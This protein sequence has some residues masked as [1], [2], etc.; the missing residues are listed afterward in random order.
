MLRLVAI[1][2]LLACT[3]CRSVQAFSGPR[4]AP[5]CELET[6]LRP[7]PA[8]A[9]GAIL[10]SEVEVYGRVHFTIR[11]LLVRPE[12]FDWQDLSR[13]ARSLA[14]SSESLLLAPRKLRGLESAFLEGPELPSLPLVSSQALY[15]TQSLLLLE[16]AASGISL[17]RR[18]NARDRPILEILAERRS[19]QQSLLSIE[20]KEAEAFEIAVLNWPDNAAGLAILV[21]MKLLA[22]EPGQAN[23]GPLCI[24]LTRAPLPLTLSSLEQASLADLKKRRPS[25]PPVLRE[26][27]GR[28]WMTER[29]VELA[30][31]A[32]AHSPD[33]RRGALLSLAQGL[34]ATLTERLCA[35]STDERLQGIVKG[36]FGAAGSDLA[37]DF[38]RA[39]LETLHDAHFRAALSSTDLA[40]L[41]SFAGALLESPARLDE[42]VTAAASL[43]ELR[44]ALQAENQRALDDSSERT[45]VLAFRYLRGRGLA[46]PGYDPLADAAERKQVNQAWLNSQAPLQRLLEKLEAAGGRND[47]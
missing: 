27:G 26:G 45:R 28:R 19:N 21:P 4:L 47:E 18:S 22:S 15:E 12:G 46:P 37:L 20:L 23:L 29:A 34:G 10:S 36:G 44:D 38:E 24:I 33:Q 1:S 7:G 5:R 11:A 40:A 8:L 41:Q 32:C 35:S 16:T 39:S 6:V 13:S 2:L 3:S 43:R 25:Q 42:L 9:S 17:R 14:S 31:Q 30:K